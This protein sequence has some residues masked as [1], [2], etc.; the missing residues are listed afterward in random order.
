MTKV[1][2]LGVEGAQDSIQSLGLHF[3]KGVPREVPNSLVSKLQ[4]HP[5]FEVEGLPLK[6]HPS[7][8][9]RQ[10]PDEI[11]EESEDKAYSVDDLLGLLEERKVTIP[12]KA[13]A[14]WDA[15]VALVEA[16]GGFPE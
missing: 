4:G 6:I 12:N 10:A 16:N 8:L 7:A 13:K 14:D 2:Y 11:Q 1:T 5:H 3:K 15:L 9:A